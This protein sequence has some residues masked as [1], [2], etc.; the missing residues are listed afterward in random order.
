[1]PISVVVLLAKYA[2]CRKLRCIGLQCERFVLL[3]HLQ[4]WCFD[5]L[6]F[7]VIESLLLFVVPVPTNVFLGKVHQGSCAIG[8]M[9]NEAPVEVRKPEE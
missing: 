7:K 8:E 4:D 5:E 3:R 9:G 2:T 6:G 1:M